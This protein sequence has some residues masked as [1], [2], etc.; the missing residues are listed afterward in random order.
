MSSNRLVERL[1]QGDDLIGPERLSGGVKTLMLIK[2]MPEMVFNASA[3]G[4]N[5]AKWLLRIAEQED[6]TV[7]HEL[8]ERSLCDPY[9]QYG[10][11]GSFHG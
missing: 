3:C 11:G 2:F 1:E 6:R 10:S 7:N 8:R 9:H 4:N 5:C